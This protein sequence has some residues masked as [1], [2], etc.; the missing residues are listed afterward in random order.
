MSNCVVCKRP[1]KRS[2]K[3]LTCTGGCDESY[4]I[5]CAASKFSINR[6][7]LVGKI[8]F[9]CDL[10]SM[11]RSLLTARTPDT[12]LSLT[13]EH[14]ICSISDPPETDKS[15]T[16]EQ[17]NCSKID[18]PKTVN[19]SIGNLG[20]ND[21]AKIDSI[22]AQISQLSATVNNR[23]DVLSSSVD[24]RL[25]TLTKSFNNVTDELR[26]QIA[27]ID[28]KY[29][30]KTAEIDT[31]LDALEDKVACETTLLSSTVNDVDAR[32][33]RVETLSITVDTR[34][35]QVETPPLRADCEIT[36]SGIPSDL[37][38][39]PKNFIANVLAALGEPELIAHVVTVKELSRKGDAK[40]QSSSVRPANSQPDQI[41]K[42]FLVGLGS[43]M[44]RDHIISLK[45]AKKNLS[46]NEV[47]ETGHNGQIYIN[48]Q[49]S[50]Y[51]YHLRKRAKARVSERG[52]KSCFI[53]GGGI[54]VRKSHG[55]PVIKIC[56][57]GDL[58]KIA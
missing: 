57:D 58:D 35:T 42:T 11:Q 17:E 27:N 33:N 50:P 40:K 52:W 46:V 39:E 45:R 18:S 54:F 7:D 6:Q 36:E 3:L 14:E 13:N 22:L 26:S 12:S 5:D 1:P 55:E 47:F 15:L 37:P 19:S 21:S 44:Y 56:S 34:L 25:D 53:D 48:E 20:V 10:C 43:T 30:A 51:L 28:S 16:N 4:H 38:L 32:L 9:R 8:S 2:G 29:D 24:K 41:F 31:K 49:L 23:F